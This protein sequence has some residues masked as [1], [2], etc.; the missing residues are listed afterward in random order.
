M[1]TLSFLLFVAAA[2]MPALAA[3]PGDEGRLEP[4][5]K[6]SADRVQRGDNQAVQLDSGAQP[7]A[8]AERVRRSQSDQHGLAATIQQGAAPSSGATQDADTVRNWR[9]N[10]RGAGT[11]TLSGDLGQVV[12]SIA[13][14]Q[15]RIR[16][17]PDTQPNATQST[18]DSQSS[19]GFAA[20]RHRDYNDGSYSRWST[21]WRHDHR[22]DWRRYRDHN[23]SLFRLGHYY[24]PFGW[25]YRRFTVG[26]SLWPSYYSSRYR[27]HDPW[28][29]RL[30]PAYGPY[31]WVRYWDDALL[32]NIYTGQVVDVLYNFF[33]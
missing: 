30:P 15:R 31:R 25:N 6:H 10:E 4:Y 9:R 12:G 13:P 21:R 29:Y 5:S 20:R 22:Y 28:R 26:F 11:P 14:R 2:G 33:W 19:T 8:R 17:I 24:D 32:V 1:R 18:S 27:L 16:T 3:D 23:R 7:A